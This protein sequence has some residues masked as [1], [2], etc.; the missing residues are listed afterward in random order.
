[1][2]RLFVRRGR[3]AGQPVAADQDAFS[4]HKGHHCRHGSLTG[5]AALSQ[6][7]PVAAKVVRRR[8]ALVPFVLAAD[9][10]IPFAELRY[11]HPYS[12]KDAS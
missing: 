11:P 5:W 9:D 7:L 2:T 10:L 12:P 6:L 1:M 8:P 4:R 3:H